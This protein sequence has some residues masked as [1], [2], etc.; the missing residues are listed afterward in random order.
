MSFN[1]TESVQTA[2]S[3][4]LNRALKDIGL[5]DVLPTNWL[6]FLAQRQITKLLPNDLAAR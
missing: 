4:R 1:P 2:V 6:S 5:N 3:R